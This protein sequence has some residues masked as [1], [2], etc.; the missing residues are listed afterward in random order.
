[1]VVSAFKTSYTRYV[2]A[3]GGIQAVDL[4]KMLT[5]G[6]MGVYP[7]WE[8]GSIYSTFIMELAKYINLD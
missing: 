1:M 7:S 6:M 2:N 5:R 4:Q 8:D 3:D